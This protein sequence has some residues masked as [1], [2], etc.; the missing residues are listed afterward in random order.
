MCDKLSPFLNRAS[1]SDGHYGKYFCVIILSFKHSSCSLFEDQVA[2]DF[3][4]MI[5]IFKW[6]VVAYLRD[7][8]DGYHTKACYNAWQNYQLILIQNNVFKYL[9][10]TLNA[11]RASG[12]LNSY[13]TNWQFIWTQVAKFIV[14]LWAHLGLVC[15]RW[16]PCWPHETC[17]QGR[18]T[19][20]WISAIPQTR[21]AGVVEP[22]PAYGREQ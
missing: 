3:I 13:L 8:F 5:P 19:Q 1:R 17:Y 6:A 9:C 18:Y 2:V 10:K 7:W 15:H 14:P 16:V 11:D 22:L 20:L 4:P 12:K 21:M